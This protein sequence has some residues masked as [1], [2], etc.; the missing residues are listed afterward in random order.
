MLL[1]FDFVFDKLEYDYNT[2]QSYMFET[3]SFEIVW[4]IWFYGLFQLMK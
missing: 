4:F 3:L 2:V 1:V